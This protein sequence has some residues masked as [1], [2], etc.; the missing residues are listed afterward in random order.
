MS[1]GMKRAEYLGNNNKENSGNYIR[2]FSVF[3]SLIILSNKRWDVVLS[4]CKI[5]LNKKKLKKN[6]CI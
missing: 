5:Q 4:T 2:Y 1:G 3:F 6:I